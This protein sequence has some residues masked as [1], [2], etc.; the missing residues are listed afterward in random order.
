MRVTEQSGNPVAQT[1]R[2]DCRL[3]RSEIDDSQNRMLWR[4]MMKF[5]KK[6]VGM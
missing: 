4:K 2:V 5:V 1:S 3:Q 6:S